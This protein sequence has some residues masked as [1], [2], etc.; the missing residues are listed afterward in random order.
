MAK[1]ASTMGPAPEHCSL[2]EEYGTPAADRG[3][4]F[5]GPIFSSCRDVDTDGCGY[6]SIQTGSGLRTPSKVE[7]HLVLSGRCTFCVETEWEKQSMVAGPD[8]LVWLLPNQMC[9]IQSASSSFRVAIVSFAEMLV[10]Q[11]EPG[12]IERIRRASRAGT[13]EVQRLDHATTRLLAHI[14]ADLTAQQGYSTDALGFGLAYVLSRLA[15]ETRESRRPPSSMPPRLHRA[16]RHA[17]ELLSDANS[18]LTIS[19]V[20][21]SAGVSYAHL[22]RLFR[23][24][25]GVTLV[26][27]VNRLRLERFS[28]LYSESGHM[29]S[30][31]LGAGF[32]SYA[33]FFRVFRAQLGVGPRE[34]LKAHQGLPALAPQLMWFATT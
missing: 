28:R 25:L 10:E 2:D 3:S 23:S 30:S 26:D 34:Y 1:L 17:V 12:L 15:S 32:G 8:A 31:A 29:L 4:G 6:V 5:P 27:Y 11:H 22:A 21:A 20:A 19:D 7:A 16:V 13:V 24:Q 9:S 14:L 33:Q 18:E